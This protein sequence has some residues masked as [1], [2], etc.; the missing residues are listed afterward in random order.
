MLLHYSYSSIGK[1]KDSTNALGDQCYIDRSSV[2]TAMQ[3][4]ILLPQQITIRY[5]SLKLAIQLCFNYLIPPNISN[6]MT[7]AI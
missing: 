4:G 6:F 7:A 2:S 5:S 3:K 1:L